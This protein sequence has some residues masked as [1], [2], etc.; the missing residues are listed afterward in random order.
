VEGREP[1]FG[2]VQYRELRHHSRVLRERWAEEL[3][4]SR[5]LHGSPKVAEVS[6]E[7]KSR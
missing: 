3:G 2:E 4:T 7:E 5:K 6:R 1:P